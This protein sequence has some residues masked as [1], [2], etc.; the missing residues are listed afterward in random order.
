MHLLSFA[1]FARNVAITKKNVV[2]VLF[3]VGGGASGYPPPPSVSIPEFRELV[4]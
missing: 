3:R 1:I 2:T 4:C